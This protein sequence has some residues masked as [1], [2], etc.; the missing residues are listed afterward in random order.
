MSH[1]TWKILLNFV[2]ILKEDLMEVIKEGQLKAVHKGFI[3]LIIA[4][5]LAY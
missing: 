2:Y 4:V 3:G 1:P 5:F